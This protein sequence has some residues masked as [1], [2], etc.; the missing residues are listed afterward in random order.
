VNPSVLTLLHPPEKERLSAQIARQIKSIILDKRIEVGERLPAERELAQSLG[1]SR[2]VVREALLSLEQS[3]YI[4]IRPGQAGGSFVTNQTY[5]PLVNC[6]ADLY[7]DG[8]QTLEHFFQAREAIELF[9][10]RRACQNID[11]GQLDELQKI[12]AKLLEHAEDK[13]SLHYINLQFHLFLAEISGNPL[14]AL[15]VEA[16]LSML[17]TIYSVPSQSA[18][19]SKSTHARHLEI[20]RA[21]GE[22]DLAACERAMSKDVEYTRR[23]VVPA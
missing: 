11:P 16:L 17:K 7:Q 9:C 21:L 18:E 4:E 22:R 3:G 10:I 8:G 23:L 20:I 15:L 19:F 5:K 12:N 1:V 6:F 2:V 14:M 13:H